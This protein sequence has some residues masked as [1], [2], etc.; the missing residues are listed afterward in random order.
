MNEDFLHYLWKYQLFQDSPLLLT[1]GTVLNILSAGE[2][3]HDSGPDFFNARIKIGET[4][5]AG[6]V[7]I[8]INASDWFRHQH[9]ADEAYQNVILH[10]VAKHDADITRKNGERIP[11]FE[12]RAPHGVYEQYLY[13]MQNKQWVPCESFIQK[14][15]V[16]TILQWKEAL[17]V[18]RLKQKSEAIAERFKLNKGHWEETFY[19]SL[20][21]NFGFKVNGQPFEM[22][23]RSLPLLYLAKHKDQ[24]SIIEAMLLGQAGLIPD[25]PST[26]YE[27][28]LAANYKHLA[29]KFNLNS[30]NKSMW[31][32]S[33]LRPGNFPTVRLAQFAALVYKSS[34][35]LSR[36]LEAK[37][38][39]EVALFFDVK[40]SGFWDTHYTFDKESHL[41]T[42]HLGEVSFQ[43]IVINTLAPFLFFYGQ[44]HK[45]SEFSERALNW[46]TEIS[47]EKNHIV[48]HWRE[49][50]VEVKNAFDSQ[51]LIQLKNVYCIKRRC[52]NCRIGNQVLKYTV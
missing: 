38:F 46:L 11:V 6:N 17:L 24:L 19:Q 27:E 50:G 3:N 36:V 48:A 12:L 44:M 30:M 47:A 34:A 23:A 45:Q 14:V 41:K 25:K 40:A 21:H 43:N 35:L 15:D 32:F 20:A 49:L 42:K 31:K 51:A 2:H 8:H 9:Q 16:F 13:L 29:A 37:S 10:V 33:K 4:V 5:W 28:D 18:E 39:E 7:E 52:L 22:L 26:P 1:D